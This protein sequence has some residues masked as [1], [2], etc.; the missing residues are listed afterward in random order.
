MTRRSP[1]L[2]RLTRVFFAM[3]FAVLMIAM[4]AFA[5]GAVPVVADSDA[6]AIFEDIETLPVDPTQEGDSEE[7][8]LTEVDQ[9]ESS[10]LDAMPGDEV[11]ESK[12]Q[13]SL[14]DL[15]L[16][17]TEMEDLAT[18]LNDAVQTLSAPE[19]SAPHLKWEVKHGYELVGGATVV[20]QAHN[21][22]NS[23]GADRRITDCM[24]D[25]PC[26]PDSLDQDPAPGKFAISQ[27]TLGTSPIKIQH[28]KPY[29]IQIASDGA[30]ANYGREST[31]WITMPR[32]SNNVPNANWPVGQAGYQ[33]TEDL[34]LSEAP[35][36]QWEVKYDG[37][38]VGGAIVSLERPWSLL[39]PFQPARTVQVEDCVVGPC[40]RISMDQDPTPGAFKVYELRW[41]TSSGFGTESVSTANRYEITPYNS[42][43]GYS[44][45]SEQ[46]RQASWQE[47]AYKFG[48]LNLSQSD[49]L[50]WTVSDEA[51]KPVGGATIRVDGPRQANNNWSN[52][53]YVT[54]CAS[55]PCHPESMDQDPREGYFRI[56]TLKGLNSAGNAQTIDTIG[57]GARY[58]VQ[59]VGSIPGYSW[60][61]TTDFKESAG[62]GNSGTEWVNGDYNFGPIFKVQGGRAASTLCTDPNRQNQYYTLNRPGTNTASIVQLSHALDERSVNSF[63]SNVGPSQT[64]LIGTSQSANSLGVTTSGIFYYTGQHGGGTNEQ[65]R[66][67]TIYRFDPSIDSAPY[68]VFNMDLLSPT[69]GTI[70]SGDATIYEGREEFYFAYYSASPEGSLP[71]GGDGVR[72]HLYRYSHGSGARTGEVT[73]VDVPR[74]PRLSAFN[75]DFA[76]DAKNNIHFI[77]SDTGPTVS[78]VINVNDFQAIDSAHSLTDVPTIRGTA[79]VANLQNGAV[80]GVAYTNN[81]RAIIQQTSNSRNQIVEMPSL[82]IR[83]S[84]RTFSGNTYV[85][86]ASCASP[87]TI[88]IQKEIIGERFDPDD[89][90]ELKAERVEGTMV[91][92]YASATTGGDQSGIQQTQLGPFAMSL[93]GEF[94]ASEVFVNADAANY[95][96]SWA[97]YARDSNGELGTPFAQGNTPELS[98]ALSGNDKPDIVL[99]GADLL[100]RF[101]NE[102]LRDRLVVE[103]LSDPA[104]G[105]QLNAG[106]V[107]EYTLKFS[108]LTGTSPATVDHVDHLSD[109]LDDSVFVNDENETVS[110]PLV[111]TTGEPLEFT[112]VD[113]PAPRI[114]F[115]GSLP[116]GTSAMASFRVKVKSNDDNFSE[117]NDKETASQGFVLR[118]YLTSGEVEPPEGCERQEGVPPTCTEHQVSAWTVF[119]DSLPADGARLHK[120]GNVH[121]RLVA[122]KLTPGTIVEELVF[123]DDLTDVFKTAGFAPDAIVPGG[124]L[125]RGIY[126]FDEFG[127]SLAHVDSG[128]EV[129]DTNDT[130][131]RSI[132]AFPGDSE[133]LVPK[134]D[135]DTNR[136]LLTS[137]SVAVP[138]NAVRAELW[139]AVQVGEHMII[140]GSWPRNASNFELVPKMGDEFTNFVT[141]SGTTPPALCET[142]SNVDDPDF[143]TA[144]QVTHELQE[145][146]FTIRK[147]AMGPGVDEVNLLPDSDPAAVRDANYGSDKSGMWNMIGHKFEI[148]DNVS[149]KPSDYQ[150]ARLCRTE[151]NPYNPN[152]GWDGTFTVP[153][154][155]SVF[156]IGEESATLAAIKLWNSERPEEEP[157]PLCALLY[158]QGDIENLGGPS[159]PGGQTGR[160][161]SENLS[162]GD[163]WL[164]E[165][166]APTHQISKNGREKRAVPGIQLLA[167]PIPFRVWPDEANPDISAAP[168]NYGLGQLDVHDKGLFSGSDWLKRCE[169]DDNAAKRPTACVNP[170]GYLLLVKDVTSIALPLSGGVGL[171]LVTAGGAV[172][173]VL[174]GIGIFWWRR[175]E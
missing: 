33:F 157:L 114:A 14:D 152:T 124:A 10:G 44:W 51:D 170:T 78:G 130:N 63:R 151:Y 5:A 121:Y 175:R 82:A 163:Y 169:P 144:C 77:V 94:R 160:W 75:G 109:V 72:F 139:F 143:P 53:Y 21:S 122:E 125:T 83:G 158:E 29:R 113:S 146:Y 105:T 84:S 40:S 86:L 89:Q 24:A 104:P 49:T 9:A 135:V 56:D 69:T 55:A 140:P 162:A 147:D 154:S 43:V 59:Q 16:S 81:G 123:T 150:S 174:A 30:P 108:N 118:N 128:N 6:I 36:L 101:T 2:R 171:A 165:T 90:F 106:D 26:G 28:G 54:D 164:V 74:P 8:S 110:A 142:G 22:G 111:K 4:T 68:A 127:T 45:V 15:A 31:D 48:I 34:Q 131:G 60:T 7:T 64:S 136:W 12:I 79:N 66:N 137:P 115:Q 167:E 25:G 42:P 155:E 23:W 95:R 107:I 133:M 172:L 141:A 3:G 41:G 62:N 50:S 93:S 38:L 148:R 96:T 98:F 129:A 61:S 87:A 103:K 116:S 65:K 119:K 27:M 132:A 52:T 88:T 32:Q 37:A 85:D 70:V 1:G 76:F 120:G 13:D 168:A 18:P 173:L 17:L 126:F 134:W 57:A 67:T 46:V 166:K 112:W 71:G 47:N 138:R 91:E 149:G 19:I 99:P 159:N 20:V 80:N 145:N 11:D 156:D 39:S 100:C 73:H 117:R 161:R 35:N 92:P 153:N 58:R 102:T 97:C